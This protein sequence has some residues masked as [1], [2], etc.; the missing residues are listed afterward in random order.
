MRLIP[1]QTLKF[2]S[3]YDKNQIPS[4]I[5]W[6][7]DDDDSRYD[8][9]TLMPMRD[10]Y[11][12]WLTR[13][14]QHTKHRQ[15]RAPNKPVHPNLQQLPQQEERASILHRY[16]LENFYVHLIEYLAL[17]STDKGSGEFGG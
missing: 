4:Q 7:H 1:L 16:N 17:H 6:K 5:Q 10:E 11:Q 13:H 12:H 9:N 8:T 3:K 14:K 15:L 2:P